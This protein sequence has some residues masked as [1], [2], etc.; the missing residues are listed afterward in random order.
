MPVEPA[1]AVRVRIVWVGPIDVDLIPIGQLVVVGVRVVWVGARD[2][3]TLVVQP[4]GVGVRPRPVG[5][6]DVQIVRDAIQVAILTPLF[7]VE[8]ALSVT[9]GVEPVR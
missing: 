5:L 1:V 4:V 9:V 8:A 6:V 2:L 7:D 3:L